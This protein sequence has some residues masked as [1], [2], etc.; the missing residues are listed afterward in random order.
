MAH[1]GRGRKRRAAG[2]RE[3]D[4]PPGRIKARADRAAAPPRAR[5]A[6]ARPLGWLVIGVATALIGW[7]AFTQHSIGD[8]FTESD[9]YGAYAPGARQLQS[10]IVDA[11]RYGIY[12]PVYETV[13]AAA[14]FVVRDL[15]TAARLISVAAFGATLVFW[16]LLLARRANAYTGLWCA[17]LLAAN[18]VLFRYGY[19]ATTDALSV[20]LQSASVFALLGARGARGPLWAGLL[21]GLAI[22]TRY[23]LA[24]LI[25]ASLACL[26]LFPA[27]R[28]VPRRRAFGAWALGCAVVLIPWTAFSLARGHIPGEG[29]FLNYGFY[30]QSAGAR[31]VQ[32]WPEAVRDTASRSTFIDLVRRD[33]VGLVARLAR[34]AGQHLV[35]DLGGLIGWLTAALAGLGAAVAWLRAG[36]RPG[37]LALVGGFAFLALVPVFYSDRYS[38]APLPFYA[39]AA[40]IGIAAPLGWRRMRGPLAAALAVAGI[41]AATLQVMECVRLQRRVA[42]A[43]PREVLATGPAL[44]ALAPDGGRVMSRKG[45]I[46]YYSGLEV[47]AFP[48]IES[49]AELGRHA[50]EAGAWFLYFSWVEAQLRPEFSYLLDTTAVIPGLEVVHA[51]DAQPGVAYRI[52]PAFGTAPDWFASDTLRNVH[53]FRGLVRAQPDSLTWQPRIFL[54]VYDLMHGRPEA[55]LVSARGIL[56]ARP[57][58]PDGWLI[59]AEALFLMGRFGEALGA[60]ESL[61]T[62]EPGNPAAILGAGRVHVAEGRYDAA[63]RL[64]RPMIGVVSAPPVLAEMIA[65]FDAIGDRE[66]AA[67]ARARLGAISR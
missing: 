52:G 1:Q 20:M 10:G 32:D 26:W 22:L 33:G 60:Y 56:R 46:G 4:P 29:L 44:A 35:R 63:A 18:P 43:L 13:L 50:H 21:A 25:P 66:A 62:I 9:F 53:T 54:G 19:S 16:F 28:D 31:H 2:K 57:R 27:E 64:W 15:F 12:G 8:Y 37:A 14:G 65:L 55:A 40:A 36:R 24:Y 58:G 17:L 6:W 47:V 42:R 39:A 61:L 23:N 7:V 3:G 48:R 51:T 38:L 45:H 5:S 34:D 59:M 41:A 30:S 49:L 67:L 11:A